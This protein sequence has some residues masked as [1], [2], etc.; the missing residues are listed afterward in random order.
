MAQFLDIPGQGLLQISELF[1]AFVLCA[2]IGVEREIRMKSAGLRTH[3]LVGV[4]AA[5]FMLISKY[6]FDNILVYGRVVLDPSRVAAQVVSGIG[7]I[8]GGV[9]FMRRDVV[10]G[11][12]TAASIWFTAALGMAC[13]AGLVVLALATVLGYFIIMLAF[14]LLARRLPRS[15]KLPTEIQVSYQ[16]GRGLLRTILV[17]CTDLRFSI[18]R[19]GLGTAVEAIGFG[20]GED[21][22]IAPAKGDVTMTMLVRGKRPISHLVAAI[23]GIDGVQEVGRVDRGSELE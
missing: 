17:K 3:T 7:F 23:S 8:G 1:L 4:S 12:T 20:P 15:R 13:G 21:H 9:I 14:P 11:L 18:D 19:V 22:E 2:L 5:L 6:G 10:R 16:D